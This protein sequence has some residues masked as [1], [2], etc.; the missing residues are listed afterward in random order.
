VNYKNPIAVQ[1]KFEELH[2]TLLPIP[3]RMAAIEAKLDA[4]IDHVMPKAKAEHAPEHAPEPSRA[5]RRG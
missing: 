3:D 2:E 1:K 5:T 4:L